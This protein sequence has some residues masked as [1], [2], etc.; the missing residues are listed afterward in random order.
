M[1]SEG[2]KKK[3]NQSLN[4]SHVEENLKKIKKIGIILQQ[5]RDIFSEMFNMN[6]KYL[7][8]LLPTK[9]LKN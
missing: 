5:V 4:R 3:V 6:M 9:E 2:N 1:D 7:L 8:Y